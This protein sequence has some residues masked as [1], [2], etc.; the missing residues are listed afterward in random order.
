[1]TLSRRVLIQTFCFCR[2][3]LATAFAASLIAFGTVAGIT[4]HPPSRERMG[5]AA[6]EGAGASARYLRSAWRHRR[7]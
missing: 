7:F 2:K 1:M 5:A 6:L 3:S 4:Y